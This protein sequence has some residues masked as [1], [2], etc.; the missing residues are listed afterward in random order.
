MPVRKKGESSKA[1]SLSA[2]QKG[3]QEENGGSRRKKSFMSF[4]YNKTNEGTGCA[5]HSSDQGGL[6]NGETVRD[7]E[8][9]SL[10]KSKLGE[11]S[12]K[13]QENTGGTTFRNTTLDWFPSVGPVVWVGKSP[14]QKGVREKWYKRGTLAVRARHRNFPGLSARPNPVFSPTKKN[15]EVGKP[16]RAS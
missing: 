12:Q 9:E 8:G 14:S 1:V 5:G 11:K 16:S 2:T 15:G 7:A 4:L 3:V 13:K 6:E 10:A